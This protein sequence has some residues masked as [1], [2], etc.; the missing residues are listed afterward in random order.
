LTHPDDILAQATIVKLYHRAVLHLQIDDAQLFHRNT[1]LTSLLPEGLSTY[2]DELL[3]LPL[4]ELAERLFTIF[5]LQTLTDESG[6]VCAFFDQLTQFCQDYG[7]DIDAFIRE[8]DETIGSKTIQ[9]TETDGIRILTIHKSKGLEF[10]NVI[11]P[12][13]DWRLEMPDVLW[14]K[15]QEE[16]FSAL[17]LAPIDYSAKQMRGTIYEHEYLDE[18][19]QNTV[20]NLNLLYVAFTRASHNLFVIGRRAAKNTRAQLIESVLPELH[21]NDA[22]LNGIDDEEAPIHFRYGTLSTTIPDGS[23]SDYPSDNVFLQP[24]R[25]LQVSIETFTAPVEFRQSNRSRDFIEGDD[26]GGE[27]SYIKMGSVLHEVFSRIRTTADINDALSQLQSEGILYNDELSREKIT[28]LLRRRLESPRISDWFSPRWQLYNE[29]SILH[30]DDDGNLVERRPDRVMTDGHE[31]HIV[32]FKFG[33][34]H[35]EYIAQV[36]E[37]MHLLSSMGLPQIHGWLWFV[38][39]NKIEEVKL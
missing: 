25:P 27:L 12:Y 35:P 32:D 34:S 16:P 2:T 39:S 3:Q 24:V 23:S 4:Y 19:L 38:Y 17:P 10:D 31:T 37:Y 1:P 20:D 29:C 18:H 14:C 9:S 11:I 6:Y 30:L 36:Q 26:E 21:L 13:A 28:S 7:T 5:Q 33:K 22:E 8:W 15:P